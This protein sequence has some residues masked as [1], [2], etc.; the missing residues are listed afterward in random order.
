[1][2]PQD[3]AVCGRNLVMKHTGRKG[4]FCSDRCRDRA[5]QDRNYAFC[6]TVMTRG[7]GVPRNAGNPYT[8]STTYRPVFAG[9]GYV[10]PQLWHAIV[11]IE[12]FADRDWIEVVST[13]NVTCLVA[14]LRPR[15][16]CEGR[17]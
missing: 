4:R 16:L 10:D 9:R 2:K 14:V 17:P 15:A 1:M 6:G 8:I 7:S 5:R 12:V 11:E 13:D 3:C